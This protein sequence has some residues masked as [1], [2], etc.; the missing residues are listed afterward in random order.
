MAQIQYLSW[1]EKRISLPFVHFSSRK[2][3]GSAHI[4]FWVV[5]ISLA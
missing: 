5:R 4:N 1:E 3:L 2:K